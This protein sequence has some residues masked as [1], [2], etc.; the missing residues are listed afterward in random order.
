MQKNLVKESKSTIDKAVGFLKNNKLVS[1]K[2]ETVYGVAC[3]P[4]SIIAIKKLYDL[5]K[6]TIL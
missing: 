2:A 1:I 4:S 5:K 3:D 6:K